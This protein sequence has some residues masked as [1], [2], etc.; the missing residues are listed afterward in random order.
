MTQIWTIITFHHIPCTG[1]R[2]VK[3]DAIANYKYFFFKRY[4]LAIYYLTVQA[5][6]AVTKDIARCKVLYVSFHVT[7]QIK[8]K[9]MLSFFPFYQKI[10]YN[11]FCHSRVKVLIYSTSTISTNAIV[12]H[13]STKY[14]ITGLHIK[15]CPLARGKVTSK[16]LKFY[17]YIYAFVVKRY[18]FVSMN[19]IFL[20]LGK[21]LKTLMS[22]PVLPLA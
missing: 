10:I 16:S 15:A 13:I 21:C 19:H 14:C 12:Y 5:C 18:N 17:L 3:Y 4:Q 20:I 1:V 9:T 22:S 7:S 6:P 8:L 2:V 11:F